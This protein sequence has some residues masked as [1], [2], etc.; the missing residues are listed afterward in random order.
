LL[1]GSEP[2]PFDLLDLADVVDL[3]RTERPREFYYLAAHHHSVAERRGTLREL[4]ET[5]Y[6]V[7]CRGLLNVLDAVVA[8]SPETR[9]F[10]ASSAL[11]FGDPRT[12]RR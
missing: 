6:D 4:F 10:Y 12:P 8:V 3:V 5:S 2:R 9:V 1:L 11:I 7:H